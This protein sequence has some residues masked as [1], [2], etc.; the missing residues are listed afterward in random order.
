VIRS[1]AIFPATFTFIAGS[2]AI[3]FRFSHRDRESW[4]GRCLLPPLPER[5]A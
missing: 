2:F 5:V 1:V 4:H 3:R